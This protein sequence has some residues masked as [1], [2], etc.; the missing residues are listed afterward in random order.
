MKIFG[1]FGQNPVPKAAANESYNQKTLQTL[2]GER[3]FERY[4]A[5]PTVVAAVNAYQTLAEQIAYGGR[6]SVLDDR[7]KLEL[8]QHDVTKALADLGVVLEF[9]PT[10]FNAARDD[11]FDQFIALFDAPHSVVDEAQA[12]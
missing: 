8:C 1:L 2:S 5:E 9:V 3:V 6:Q 12:A 11:S 10:K 7:R 4:G